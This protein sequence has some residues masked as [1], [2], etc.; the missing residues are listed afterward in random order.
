MVKTKAAH[1][2]TFAHF[3]PKRLKLSKLYLM[4]VLMRKSYRK[5]SKQFL[6]FRVVSLCVSNGWPN[7]LCMEY[8][9]INS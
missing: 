3:S 5:R 7:S 9:A 2:R 4:S 1:Q 8:Y 6:D